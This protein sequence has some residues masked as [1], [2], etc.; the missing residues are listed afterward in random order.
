MSCRHAACGAGVA[1]SGHVAHLERYGAACPICPYVLW[2]VL[3]NHR[4]LLAARMPPWRHPE[5]DVGWPGRAG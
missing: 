3:Q 4:I 5:V 1:S 2:C